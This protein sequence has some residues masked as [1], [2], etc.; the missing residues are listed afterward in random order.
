[1]RRSLCA[2]ADLLADPWMVVIAV[3]AMWIVAVC[4]FSDPS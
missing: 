1:V 3:V 2:V 4:S